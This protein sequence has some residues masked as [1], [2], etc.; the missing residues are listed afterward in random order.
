MLVLIAPTPEVEKELAEVPS[1][2]WVAH[3]G[4]TNL[5]RP[6]PGRLAS[7]SL[8]VRLRR[9]EREDTPRRMEEHARRKARMDA[10]LGY[11]TEEEWEK[12]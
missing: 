4:A 9:Q 3:V 12:L 10:G 11:W 5:D 7:V 6:N 8:L 1:A 2:R